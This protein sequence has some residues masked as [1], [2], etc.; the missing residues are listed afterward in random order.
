MRRHALPQFCAATINRVAWIVLGLLMLAAAQVHA[1]AG[2]NPKYVFFFIGDGMAMP[3]RSAAE[4]FLAA[5]DGKAEPGIVKLTMNQMPVQGMTTTYSL[6][7]I[8]TDSGAAGTDLASGVKS[9]NGAI[10]VDGAKKPVPTMAEKARDK[11]YKVGIVSSVGLLRPG[12]VIG[13][14]TSDNPKRRLPYTLEMTKV[15]DFAGDFWVGVNT[16]TP[17]RLLRRAVAARAIPELAGYDAARPEPPFAD[18]RLDFLLTGP[19]GRCFV[20]CKNVTMV[21]DDAARP[22]PPFAEGRL[23]FLLTG[24]A[25]RCFVE[26][27][28]VTMVEDGAAMFP[29]AATERGRKHLVELTR[30]A[31][32]GVD[33]AAIFYCVQRPDGRCFAPADVIDPQYAEL[34][35]EAAAAGVLILP[36]RAAVSAAGVELKE[37]LP[38]ARW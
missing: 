19:A 12:A 27:K 31:R 4:Y 32:E 1:D 3:Q 10:G 33:K 9:Y 20:E 16:L 15:P 22:E 34:L 2:K 11:G 23:D 30:L 8:I 28:N 25:G 24:P 14:S 6:N 38:L 37:V 29:D 35:T 18:G 7:S 21:E 36:Y 17:N 5:K 13:L 26:C